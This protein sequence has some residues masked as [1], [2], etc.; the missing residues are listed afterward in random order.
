MALSATQS[1]GAKAE[2]LA[3]RHL[4]QQDLRCLQSNFRCRSGEIDLIMLDEDCLVFVEVRFR[5]RNRF[6]TAALS[7][8]VAKQRKIIRAAAYFIACRQ[9]YAN[10]IIRFDVVGIDSAMPGQYTI[11]WIRDAF[12]P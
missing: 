12:R 10:A 7:I 11:Q 5:A 9:R 6:T 4:Q 3:L 2:R 8:G 1:I